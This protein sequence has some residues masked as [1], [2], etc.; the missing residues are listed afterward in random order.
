MA[1]ALKISRRTFLKGTAAAGGAA[2]AA[3]FLYRGLDTLAGPDGEAQA[4]LPPGE[5]WIATLC[6]IGKQDCGVRARRINGRVVKLEGNG[7]HPRNLGTLCPKGMAQI[8]ALYD[9]HRVRTPLIRTNDKGV[10]GQFRPA[11][12]D[13]ALDLVASKIREAR[14]KDPKLVVWQKGRSKSAALYDN[15]FATALGATKL[16]HGA[17]CSDAGYRASEY[18]LGLN[19]VLHPDYKHCRYIIHWGYNLTAGGGN[20]L[21]WITFPRQVVEAKERGAKIVHIDPRLHSA[22]PHADWWIPIR[23]GTDLALALAL[24]NRV[25]ERGLVDKDYLLQYTN[26][27]FLVQEDGTFLRVDG[28]EQ[29]WDEAAGQ[30]VPYDVAT[31]PFLDGVFEWQ[32]KRL[33][34]AFRV[35]REHVAPYTPEWASQICDIPA[36]DIRRLADEMV[37]NA[38]IGSTM[39]VDGVEIPHRPV[40]I[41]TY[42]FAQQELGFQAV[43]AMLILMMLLGAP[44]AV[45][46]QFVDFGWKKHANFDKFGQVTVKDPPYNIWLEN[47]PFFP[48][49][50]NNSAVVALAL[51]DPQGWQVD[52]NKLP[53]VMIIHMTN[54]V[55]AFGSS[56]DILEGFKRIPFIVVLDPWLSKT[57]DLLADVVLPVST[58]EKYE[59]PSSATDGYVD[60][61][62]LRIPVMEPL[63]ESR[64]E[65]E[66]YLDLAERVGVLNAYLEAL[67]KELGLKPPNVLA[68]GRKPT[69]REV[70]EL[71][72]KSQGVAEG[73]AYFEKNGVLV[74]GRL[75]PDKIYGYAQKPPFGGIRHR[76]Y[77]ESL[78]LMQR[79]ARRRGVDQVF[80]RDYTPL[81][82][83]REPTMERSPRQY[84][85]Y[86]ISFKLI[87]FKQGRGTNLPLVAELAPEQRLWMHPRAAQERGIKDGDLVWVE[88]HNA[89]TGETRRVRVRVALTEGIR[90]DTVGLP[91]HYGDIARHPW[92][93]N[94]GP[95]AAQL[96]FTGPGYMANTADQSFQVKVRV[97]KA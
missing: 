12:W 54:P 83:W 71:W 72:A 9:P 25:L 45:G 22:G 28:R 30:P 52:P 76:L 2:A 73:L 55:V 58:M 63:G 87:E 29:V 62:A 70:F 51:R 26:A 44:G 89:F 94:Q 15:S 24:I 16:H 7:A 34:T 3:T 67:N 19:G 97:Y 32:G 75:T 78:L 53:Q 65:L 47:S 6:W 68:P 84:D 20:K 85:L 21:C 77:G 43:R 8:T 90:P 5:E 50:S 39:V 48:I 66:I 41:H 46:G 49:N 95:G 93:Q 4:Q 23:P 80:W 92:S 82:V 36:R 42:H 35:L 81:P 91:H 74:K 18:T 27:P 11:S 38:L 57:A 61:V 56:P 40:A 60:A 79:E 59:G 31:R 88:S 17:F 1:M 69:P 86:L 13:E 14:A 33:R 96:F 10:P 64:S 37:D